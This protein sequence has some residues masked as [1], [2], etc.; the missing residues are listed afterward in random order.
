MNDN[1]RMTFFP[2]H[3][4]EMYFKWMNLKAIH[5]AYHTTAKNTVL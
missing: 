1:N 3:D 2:G 4:E 5:A